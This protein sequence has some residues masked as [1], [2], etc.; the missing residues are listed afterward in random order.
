LVPLHALARE[1]AAEGSNAMRHLGGVRVL[2]GAVNRQI[3]DDLV[4][5][6]D[7]Q[8]V[9]IELVDT[10]NGAV[11]PSGSAQGSSSRPST[12][13]SSAAR[14]ATA[15]VPDTCR[16]RDEDEQSPGAGIWQ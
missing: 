5:V 7:G 15:G 13:R 10:P 6:V 14:T 1:H 4:T 9:D 8:T 11:A 16:P 3:D 2:G 12:L